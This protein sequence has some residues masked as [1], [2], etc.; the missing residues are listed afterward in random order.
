[1]LDVLVSGVAGG[2]YTNTATVTGV[3]NEANS[4]SATASA[5]VNFWWYGRTPGYWK[6]QPEAWVNGY[7]PGNFIQS[8]FNVPNS[9]LKSGELDLDRLSGKDTLMDGLSYRGGSTLSGGAQILFRAAIAA[10][11]NE[12][13]YGADFPIAT[14]TADLIAQVNAVLA[15][16]S[17]S[18]YVSFA[19]YLDYWNNAVHAS[20]P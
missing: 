12:A 13:Y 4:D 11:L 18:T 3:D 6:N 7:L 9:L 16:G 8:V 20:L 1:V 14:S 19:S 15:S 2:T 17:R 10:L 5:N